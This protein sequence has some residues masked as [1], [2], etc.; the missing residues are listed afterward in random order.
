[1]ETFTLD[2]VEYTATQFSQEV[3]QSLMLIKRVQNDKVEAE[4]EMIKCQATLEKLNAAVSDKVRSE[5]EARKNP[6]EKVVAEAV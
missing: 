5:L 3:Q 2:G 4:I 6:P 1:M